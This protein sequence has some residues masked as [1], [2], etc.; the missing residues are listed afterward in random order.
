MALYENVFYESDA[1]GVY[2]MRVSED[3]AGLTGTA[4]GPKTDPNVEVYAGGSGRKRNGI[5]ARGVRIYREVGV[6]DSA[7][8]KYAFIPCATTT[9]MADLFNEATI[10]YKTLTW[11]PATVVQEK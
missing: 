11:K 1:G 5:H 9:I 2:G 4:A 6:G 7:S 8:K 3:K 10:T